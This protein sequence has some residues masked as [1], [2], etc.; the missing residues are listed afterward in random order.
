MAD[1]SVYIP[2]DDTHNSLIC[3]LDYWLKRLDT[4]LKESTNQNSIKY[5]KLLSQLIRERY[6][7]ILGTSVINSQ[8]SSPSVDNISPTNV[9]TFPIEDFLITRHLPG[10]PNFSG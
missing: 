8:I 9:P 6:N 2:N 5:P 1:K 4:Q 10:C 3:R 7:K